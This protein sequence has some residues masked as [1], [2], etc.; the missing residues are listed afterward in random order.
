MRATRTNNVLFKSIPNRYQAQQVVSLCFLA[1]DIV[2]FLK[3]QSN[4][5]HG[6]SSA[7]KLLQYHEKTGSSRCEEN[8]VQVVVSPA[9]APRQHWK[10]IA[11]PSPARRIKQTTTSAQ[12]ESKGTRASVPHTFIKASPGVQQTQGK[13]TRHVNARPRACESR[14][15]TRYHSHFA[16]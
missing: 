9:G 5:C 13:F 12:H 15:Q 8:A 2:M 7:N 1:N 3:N 6:I 14:R 4:K 16:Q 10:L 11:Q